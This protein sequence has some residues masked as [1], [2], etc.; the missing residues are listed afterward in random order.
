MKFLGTEQMHNTLQISSALPFN[1]L[2]VIDFL[3]TL[4]FD[5][6]AWIRSG[7]RPRHSDVAALKHFI[8]F[9]LQLLGRHRK[10]LHRPTQTQ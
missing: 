10:A 1:M 7:E 8:A 2:K 3:T 6:D 5:N 9:H 4:C